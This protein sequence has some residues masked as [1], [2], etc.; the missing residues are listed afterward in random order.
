MW[1]KSGA[2]FSNPHPTSTCPIITYPSLPNTSSAHSLSL[3]SIPSSLSPSLS[4]ILPLPPPSNGA[5]LPWGWGW[6]CC[7]F[8]EPRSPGRRESR[9]R[10][11]ESSEPRDRGEQS[12][13]PG[14]RGEES[15]EPGDRGEQSSEP[16]DRGEQSSEPGD[17]GEQSSEPG[18]R[19]E[20]SSEPGDRGEQSSEP[21]DRGE[22]S[23]E[24]G[25]RGEENLE[26]GESRVQSPETGE[27]R[28]QSPETG[29]RRVQSPETGERRVQSPGTGESRVQSPGTGESRVQSPEPGE[30][31]VQSPET[32]E[33]RVQSPERGARSPGRGES[34][35][36]SPGRAEFR[37]RSLG[38]AESRARREEPGARGEQS[39]EP[40]DRGEESPE[41][42]ERSPEPGESRV[43]SPE[44]GERRVQS[45]ERGARSPGRAEFRARR[46]GRGESRARREEPGARGEQSSEPG[47]AGAKSQEREEN[48]VGPLPR[49]GMQPPPRKV[50]GSP[51][52]K[53]SFSE[54]LCRAQS[55]QQLE[56]ELLED[57]RSFSKQRAAIEKEYGQALQRLAAQYLK[58]D[59]S[60]G[61]A[62]ATDSRTTFT[63]WRSTIEATAQLGQAHAVSAETYRTVSS[64]A[65][66]TGRLAKDVRLKKCSE[67]LLQVQ[68]E[69]TEAVKELNK[70]K[71]RYAQRQRVAE[72]AQ[73]KAAEAEAKSKKSE[74]GIFHSKTSLQKLSVKL[75]SRLL[76]CNQRLTEARNEY[77]L[78]LAAVTA[79]QDHYL[80]SDL[81]QILKNLDGDMYEKLQEFLTLISKAEMDTSQLGQDC[82]Q[83]VL[84]SSRKVSRETDI[85][86]FLQENSIFTEA[87][88]FTFQPLG[89]DKVCHLVLKAGTKDGET[90]LEKEAQK[91]AM[92]LANQHKVVAH[93]DRVLQSLLRRSQQLSEEEAAGLELKMEEIRESIRKAEV[94]KQKAE[95]R[96]T[97]LRTA[98][99]EVDVWVSSTMSQAQEELERERRLSEARVSNGGPEFTEL[100]FADFEEFED[101]NESTEENQEQAHFSGPHLYPVHCTAIYSYQAVQAD[102]LTI[103]QGEALE[104]IEDGDTEGWVK[105]RNI[106]A[107]IGYIPESYLQFPSGANPSRNSSDIQDVSWN[108][109][110]GGPTE[111]A[112]SGERLAVALYDYQ[113]QSNE[114]L[115]F[116]EGAVIRVLHTGACGVD[117]GFW[118]GEYS[119]RAG[120][121]P[122]LL[123]ELLSEGR[124]DPELDPEADPSL[125]SPPPFSP[126]APDFSSP[127]FHP[128]GSA[129][130]EECHSSPNPGDQRA[131][132]HSGGP[133]S[134]TPP[135]QLTP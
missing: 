114:E 122:S 86:L 5:A 49:D 78:T 68:A 83:K 36:R 89:S 11:E 56:L 101:G 57:L 51:D 27:S 124:A 31:R 70:T 2:L 117:D 10:G 20:Q 79:H 50:R 135:A 25:D 133:G 94:S 24:P 99:V 21:G 98:G 116:P 1:E 112:A 37:A 90:G 3:S 106:S 64:E 46:P 73:E 66:R 113:G 85:R 109:T 58:K 35:A 55:R 38:R 120:V 129:Q 26:T 43:Q 96:L 105:A 126:P 22:Q 8:A 19:G 77:L 82:F 76:E 127:S 102:E 93:G 40:G 110:P 100:D 28:V 42:G 9:D 32:G 81:P 67:Q 47:E 123:V 118:K 12:S 60:R 39:S 30:S 84:E 80:Q 97:L 92:K 4:L 7:E 13:E 130:Q 125:L 63:A 88:T 134:D 75:S 17:R 131:T 23:S 14:D 69:L 44:T 62:D 65:G 115:C 87:A 16:G 61:K 59:S 34:R 15:S 53:F 121:F 6:S 71:K 72:M 33:R 95:A 18:D 52:V 41:P 45:P 29:E 91:W 104:V 128:V 132:R 54:Q 103:T 111:Q 74:F 107:Q 108:F 48:P 119:G